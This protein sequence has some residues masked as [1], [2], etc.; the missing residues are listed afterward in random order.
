MVRR[1]KLK[2][3][4]AFKAW[5]FETGWGPLTPAGL[6][7]VSVVAAEVFTG[8]VEAKPGPGEAKDQAEVRATAEHLAR[9]DEASKL[10]PLFAAPKGLDEAAAATAQTEEGW[11]LG[12]A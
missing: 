8:L 6:E 2:Y 4:D 3:G 9:L 10:S 11:I 12:A 1:L 7:G 5:P